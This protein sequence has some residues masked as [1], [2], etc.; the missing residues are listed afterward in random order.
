MLEVEDGAA[1]AVETNLLHGLCRDVLRV[2]HPKQ[3][4]QRPLLITVH[5]VQHRLPATQRTPVQQRGFT[6]PSQPEA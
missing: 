1:L 2:A 3:H 4:I 6:P 5:R